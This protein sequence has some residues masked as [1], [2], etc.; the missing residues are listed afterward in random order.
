VPFDAS[1]QI[2]GQVGFVHYRLFLF[3]G[4]SSK[5]LWV[6]EKFFVHYCAN[7]ILWEYFFNNIFW[8]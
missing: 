1:G 7:N 3:S 4:F 5:G 2:T 6:M 8:N